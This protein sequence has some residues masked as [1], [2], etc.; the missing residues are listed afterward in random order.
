L[1]PDT[2]IHD[3]ALEK[4]VGFMDHDADVGIAGCRVENPDGS[5]QRACRRSIPTPTIAL[6]RLTGLSRICPKS[7]IMSKY[8]L[9]YIRE[10]KQIEVDAV[11]GSFLMFRNEVLED[12]GGFDEDYFMYAEDMDF[13]YR[14]KMKGW[15]V[16]YYPTAR[17]THIKGQSSKQLSMKTTKAFYDSM[18]IFFKKNLE[19]KTFWPLR[20]LVYFGIWFLKQIAIFRVLINKNKSAGSKG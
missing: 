19:R 11:S 4:M 1:N 5:L 12:I 15:G 3:N 9:S 7:K 10:T 14:A 6:F 17:I 2:I 20:F 13:C 18:A 8:N 16:M